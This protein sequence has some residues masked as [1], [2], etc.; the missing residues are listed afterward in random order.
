MRS[1]ALLRSSKGSPQKARLII[2]QI[3]GRNVTE[4]LALL[5]LSRKRLA[6][7]LRKVLWSAISNAEYRAEQNNIQLNMEQLFVEECSV[8]TGLTKYRRRVRPAPM[9]RAYREQRRLFNVRVVLSD[10]KK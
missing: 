4:A 9:G 1:T 5:N 8:E 6:P 7:I 2:D 10:D 3:R